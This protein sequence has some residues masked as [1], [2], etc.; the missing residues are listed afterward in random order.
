MNTPA[1][2][3]FSCLA[4]HASLRIPG[5]LKE[6]YAYLRKEKG[7]SDLA[8]VCGFLAVPVVVGAITICLV[9]GL[10][11]RQARILDLHGHTE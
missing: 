10:Y 2:I 11:Q 1:L 9:D 4:M 8:L 3:K 6:V 5:A 7:L